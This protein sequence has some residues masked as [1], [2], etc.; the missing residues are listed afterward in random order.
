[1][2]TFYLK[3]GV[4]SVLLGAL[5]D[6][7]DSGIII[8]YIG[9]IYKTISDDEFVQLNGFHANVLCDELPEKIKRFLVDT[10]NNPVREFFK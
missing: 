4:E 7:V 8:D 6:V 10:P 9:P 2:K 5:E 3:H 1:M